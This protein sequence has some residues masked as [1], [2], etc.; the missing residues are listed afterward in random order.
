MQGKS[1][2]SYPWEA[3]SLVLEE[4][5]SMGTERAHG[6]RVRR[7][8]GEGVRRAVVGVTGFEPATS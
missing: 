8:R 2:R 6:A 1:R 7:R 3:P 4:A 5:S